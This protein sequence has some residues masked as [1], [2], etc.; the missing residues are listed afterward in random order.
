MS[1]YLT[2]KKTCKKYVDSLNRQSEKYQSMF[3]DIENMSPDKVL[4]QEYKQPTVFKS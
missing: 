3:K 1:S 4:G 2:A